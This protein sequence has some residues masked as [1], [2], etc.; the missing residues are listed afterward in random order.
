MT[1]TQEVETMVGMMK[2]EI[3]DMIEKDIVPSTVASFS[4]LHDYCDAN[5]LGQP[6]LLDID[7]SE[8]MAHLCD[9]FNAASNDV[10]AWIKNGM[11]S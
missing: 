1:Q 6:E 5:M 10:D 9:V 8:A 7:D 11:P 2:A 4:E 3:T